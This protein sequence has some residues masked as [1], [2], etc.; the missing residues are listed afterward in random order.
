M[1]ATKHMISSGVVGLALFFLTGCAPAAAELTEV[2]K[3]KILAFSEP[4]VDAQ[5]AAI[6]ASDYEA[7]LINYSADLQSTTT[8]GTFEQLEI[9]L[10]V[11]A[12][13]YLSREVTS[14]T[15]TEDLYLVEYAAVFSKDSH[16]T[17]QVA[18]DKSAP[19]RIAGMWFDS[20][21]MRE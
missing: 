5:M 9:W 7:F 18:F 4:M 16:V 13:K 8:L 10:S 3:T 20:P 19:N 11:K 15:Q 21:R 2:E 1:S 17:M 12:G 6:T 14:V